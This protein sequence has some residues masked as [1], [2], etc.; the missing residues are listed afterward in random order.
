MQIKWWAIVN[1]SA[2]CDIRSLCNNLIR[3]GEMKGMVS[4]LTN[5]IVKSCQH[6][7]DDYF[8]IL[9]LVAHK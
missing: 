6:S 7:L 9:W 1:F 3:C 8:L 4:V 2:R 5:Y